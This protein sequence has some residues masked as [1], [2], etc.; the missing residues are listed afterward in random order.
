MLQSLV[1]R[2]NAFTAPRRAVLGATVHSLNHHRVPSTPVPRLSS[3]G[4]VLCGA[5]ICNCVKRDSLVILPFFRCNVHQSAVAALGRF[6]EQGM[7]FRHARRERGCD[8]YRS[9]QYCCP[10]RLI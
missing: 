9:V 4:A 1:F 3:R 5:Y 2:M 7:C 6:E 10:M 8:L